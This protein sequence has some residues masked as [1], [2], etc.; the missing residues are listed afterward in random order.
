M[1]GKIWVYRDYVLVVETD[2]PEEVR[3]EQRETLLVKHFILRR[4]RDY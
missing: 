2:E 3:D 1:K 4:E